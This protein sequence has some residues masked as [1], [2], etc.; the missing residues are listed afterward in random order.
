VEAAPIRRLGAR[1]LV[2][3]AADRVL[4]FRGVD[5]AVPDVR[6]WFTVGGGLDDGET[7]R[8]G[9]AREL[10]EET[11]LRV[12]PA[13]LV[14]PVHAET[15]EFSFAGQRYR[16]EQEFFVLRAGEWAVDTSGFEE[17][18]RATID[19]WRWWSAA[20]LRASAETYY[21]AQLPVL[22][23]RAAGRGSKR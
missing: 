11:G 7:P 14:G 21:P 13:Q 12:S 15:T 20:E 4:L 9:A 6:Y 17:V 3:D 16:Q 19:A 10:F 5:P 18:E 1:V 8:E 2:L 23:E 22:V